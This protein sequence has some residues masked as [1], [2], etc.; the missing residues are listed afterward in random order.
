[1]E[2][3]LPVIRV[4]HTDPKWGPAKDSDGF[5]FMPSITVKDDDPKV[6]KNFPNS[7]KKTNLQDLLREKGCNTVFLCGLSSTGCVL[8]TYHGA[9]D[10]D[11]KVFMVKDGL[12]GPD[13]A[14]TDMIEDICDSVGFAALEAIL[15]SLSP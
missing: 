15:D 6:I 12:I 14:Q 5:Q 2:R 13:A 7:F 9:Q 3:G 1:M 11:Y 10:L 4:Y 8:A